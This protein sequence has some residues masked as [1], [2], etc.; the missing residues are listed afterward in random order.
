MEAMIRISI[1]PAAFEAVAATLPL[2]SVGY[3]PQLDRQGQRLIWLEAAV[4]DRLQAMRGPGEDYSD[5]IMRLARLDG[6]IPMQKAVVVLALIVLTSSDNVHAQQAQ[7]GRY[8]MVTAASQSQSLP[9]LFLL[10]TE[11][12]QSWKLLRGTGQTE[13]WVPVRFST[14]KGQALVPLPPSPETIGVSR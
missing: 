2:G 7:A 3:E 9:E 12:G 4:V 6:Q 8:Q 5:V 11:T 13:E 10:N 14:G 1:T